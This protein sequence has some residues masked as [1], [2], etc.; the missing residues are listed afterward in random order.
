MLADEAFQTGA[1]ISHTA[2]LEKTKCIR[3][4]QQQ[5]V[6]STHLYQH[7]LAQHPHVLSRFQHC[8]QQPM[9]HLFGKLH[10]PVMHVQALQ[11]SGCT[12]CQF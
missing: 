7:L 9:L 2:V 1:M 8:K 6:F 10:Q 3:L 4:L 5:I 12:C 11:W